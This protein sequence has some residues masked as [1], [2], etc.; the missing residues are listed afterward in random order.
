MYASNIAGAAG[1]LAGIAPQVV[2][3]DPR[4]AGKLGMDMGDTAGIYTFLN[5]GAYHP[6]IG[7]RLPAGTMLGVN[8]GDPN[9]YTVM[10]DRALGGPVRVVERNQAYA[11][12]NTEAPFDTVGSHQINETM[13]G[14]LEEMIMR[15]RMVPMSQDPDISSALLGD[16]DVMQP[17]QGPQGNYFNYRKS[18]SA[19]AVS[20][21]IVTGKHSVSHD[22]LL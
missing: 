21:P 16:T 7:K 20:P 2:A 11:Y 18:Q 17:F 19:Q 6:A 12:P 22:H 13:P 1:N 3:I 9:A 14:H 8:D 10:N 15:D 4:L 5:D